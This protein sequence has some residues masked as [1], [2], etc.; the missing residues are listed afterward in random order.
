MPATAA[1]T[2]LAVGI[3]TDAATAT[4]SDLIVPRDSACTVTFPAPPAVTDGATVLPS[5]VPIRAAT[6]LAIVLSAITA[7]AARPTAALP[8]DTASDPAPE[9]A[10]IVGRSI[11][12]SDTFPLPDEPAAT[13]ADRIAAVV[14]PRMSL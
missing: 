5:A 4:P 9:R 13:V 10:S 14:V 8:Q 11:A 1:E 12:V 7:P 2:G 3:A 6:V